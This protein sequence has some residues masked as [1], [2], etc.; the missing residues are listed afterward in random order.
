MGA[1][2]EVL[3]GMDVIGMGDFSV[4]SHSGKTELNFSCPPQGLEGH[5]T[6]M[7]KTSKQPYLGPDL[8]PVPG[9]NSP[10]TP[11]DPGIPRAERPKFQ[12]RNSPCRCGSRKSYKYCHG[13]PKPPSTPYPM[14]ASA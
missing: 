4:T 6:L 8:K 2:I 7:K 3:I 14:A 5:V 10:S 12:S 1:D 9:P 11:V 13:G